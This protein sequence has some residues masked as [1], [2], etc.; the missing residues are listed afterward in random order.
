MKKELIIQPLLS[1]LAS[2]KDLMKATLLLRWIIVVDELSLV[3]F[4]QLKI[5]VLFFPYKNMIC[6]NLQI[7]RAY[8]GS[9]SLLRGICRSP[10][11]SFARTQAAASCWS[12][13][14]AEADSPIVRFPRSS[15][16]ASHCTHTAWT[17]ATSEIGKVSMMNDEWWLKMIILSP[18][19]G[20]SVPWIVAE[21]HTRLCWPRSSRLH[22]PF[23]RPTHLDPRRRRQHS[24]IEV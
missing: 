10:S 20:V 4:A 9:A 19:Q 21:Q 2:L 23:S 1:T 14:M 22:H 16:T 12:V 18:H 8:I 11:E 6:E 15:T 17:Y 24:T 3:V 7:S 13:Q 5:L